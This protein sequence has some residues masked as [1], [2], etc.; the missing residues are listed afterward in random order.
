[1]NINQKY[2][3]LYF[4]LIL[5]L[6]N[7]CK[8][9]EGERYT[10][11]DGHVMD[12]YSNEPLS[13]IG[14]IIEECEIILIGPTICTILDTLYSDNSG[15]FHYVLVSYY[16][17]NILDVSHF[18]LSVITSDYY[19]NN[20]ATMIN[21]G[22]KNIFDFKIK[23]LRTLKVLLSDTSLRYDKLLISIYE[24]NYY[25]NNLFY[26]KKTISNPQLNDKVFFQFKPE[27]DHSISWKYFKSGDYKGYDFTHKYFRNLDTIEFEIKY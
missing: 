13:N 6:L 14:L 24:A 23:P 12:F 11:I 9:K 8:K 4:I 18:Q 22:E 19:A 3:L 7:S 16:P 5:F 17:E 15:F 2:R 26:Q 1:M 20:E 25:E 21:I 27:T 10:S